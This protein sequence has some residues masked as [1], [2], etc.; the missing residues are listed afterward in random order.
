PE[1]AGH[2][3]E[4]RYALQGNF[5]GIFLLFC[6][7]RILPLAVRPCLSRTSTA[8]NGNV[9]VARRAN[10]R[11]DLAPIAN[12]CAPMPSQ[13]PA[14]TQPESLGQINDQWAAQDSNL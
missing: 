7:L 1:S 3:K 10:I 6:C 14:A 5:A 9:P 8:T 11:I 2:S 4:E 12:G 13:A